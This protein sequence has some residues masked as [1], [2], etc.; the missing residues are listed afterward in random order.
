[1]A[2]FFALGRFNPIVEGL[3]SLPWGRLLR[4]PAKF[5]LLG[6]LGGSLL[7]GL[8]FDSALA[9][10]RRTC[11]RL[12]ALLA[13]LYALLLA[14][15]LAAPARV[16]ARL[17]G[18]LAP[19][20]PAPVLR[21]DLL[22]LEGLTLSVDRTCPGSPRR[23]VRFGRRA[24]VAAGVA[25]VV[26]QAASQLWAMLPAVPMDATGPSS[27][28]H[29]CWQRSPPA[30]SSCTAPTTTSSGRA[31]CTRATIPTAASSG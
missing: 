14:G 12:L 13:A 1:M 28:R 17:A 29:R 31:R 4:F 20:L 18:L 16:G 3:W 5:W 24:P 26:L 7:C 30:A 15:A 6:A 21:G 19:D 9:Q 2:L 10:G 27:P 8:G 22:R 25:L 23:L 11:A